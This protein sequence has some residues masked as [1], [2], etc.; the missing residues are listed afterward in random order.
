M[1]IHFFTSS[2]YHHKQI[3]VTL[4]KLIENSER[5]L[6]EC[7]ALRNLRSFISENTKLHEY[8]KCKLTAAKKP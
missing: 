1:D 8:V 3:R 2:T 7:L 6:Q 5:L 4:N